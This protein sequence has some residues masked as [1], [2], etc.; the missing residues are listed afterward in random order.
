[1]PETLPEGKSLA[2]TS[3]VDAGLRAHANEA[4]PCSVVVDE[5]EATPVLQTLAPQVKGSQGGEDL[6]D[7]DDV[8]RLSL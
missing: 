3:R 5:N 7:R 4:G 6:E 8:A 1:M 2:A